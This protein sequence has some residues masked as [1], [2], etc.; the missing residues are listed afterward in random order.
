MVFAPSG[1]ADRFL[2]I[3]RSWKTGIRFDHLK[4]DRVAAPVPD[5]MIGN[6][7][8]AIAAQRSVIGGI[9]LG[10]DAVPAERLLQQIGVR[11]FAAVGTRQTPQSNLYHAA[12]RAQRERTDPGQADSW[13]GSKFGR[14][15]G[16]RIAA[17]SALGGDAK[18]PFAPRRT[19]RMRRRA[20]PRCA[21]CRLGKD[22]SPGSLAAGRIPQSNMPREAFSV[23]ALPPSAVGQYLTRSCSAERIANIEAQAQCSQ[24]TRVRPPHKVDNQ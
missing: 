23:R 9:R 8:T 7:T 16:L 1:H 22:D 11:Q 17:A 14:T 24:R 4:A 3:Q 2:Q 13:I 5:A 19:R 20:D 12:P 10:D 21:R 6:A 15:N 18:R